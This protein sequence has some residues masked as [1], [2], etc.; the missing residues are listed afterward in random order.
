[1]TFRV[2]LRALPL[3]LALT[4][5][6]TEAQTTFTVT[7]VFPTHYVI[8]G[9]SDPTLTIARG[10]TYNFTCDNCDFHPFR[11]Q[12]TQGFNG[13]LYLNLLSGP[14]PGSSTWILTVPIEEQATT[15]LF[16]QCGIHAAMNGTIN[17]I[18]PPPTSTPPPTATPTPTPTPVPCDGDC[19]GN[20]VVTVGDLLI[21]VNV[22]LGSVNVSTCR[23]GDVNRDSRITVDELL[24][25]V[26]NALNGCPQFQP[27]ET[28]PPTA[29]DVPPPPP[30]PTEQPRTEPPPPPPT[31]TPLPTVFI[32]PY[33]NPY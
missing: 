2:H 5:A 19:D 20:A 23:E 28:P 7:G 32:P 25:G 22:A 24:T 17:V 26:D 33:Y 31:A 8:N 30:P 1:M 9:Q 14:N 4:A 29:T 27:L 10:Q 15:T 21:M 6:S 16:Y 12:S 18:D 13:T 3:A 11:I